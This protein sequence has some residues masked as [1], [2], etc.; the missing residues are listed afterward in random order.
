MPSSYS[1]LGIE[2]IDTGE[3]SGVWGNTTNTNFDILDDSIAGVFSQ[4]LTGDVTLSVSDGSTSGA[5]HFILKFTSSLSASSSVT[6]TIGTDSTIKPYVIQ[7][8]CDHEVVINQ[9]S[10]SGSGT[11][12]TVPAGQFRFIYCDGGGTNANVVD[13]IISSVSGF[14]WQPIITSATTMVAGRGYFVNTAGSAITMTLPTTAALGAALR[15]VDLGSANTNAVTVARN[16]HKIMGA[17]ED[18]VV[19]TPNAAF[20]LIYVD[21]TFGWRL[22]EV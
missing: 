14:E 11:K 16:G 3:Q 13:M 6:V 1:N 9:G 18:L 19:N 22:L 17:S 10:T 4:V 15:I 12:V 20:G 7:N 8:A 21:T 5:G 2:K